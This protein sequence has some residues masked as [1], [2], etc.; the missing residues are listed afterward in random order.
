MD[1]MSFYL[2]LNHTCLYT[3]ATSPSSSSTRASLCFKTLLM[4][5]PSPYD[6]TLTLAIP[7]PPSGAFK[8]NVLF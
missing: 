2:S 6:F 5:V 8:T 3:A 1:D 4:G 7:Q